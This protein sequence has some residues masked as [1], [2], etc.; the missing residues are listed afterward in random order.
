[1]NFQNF[2]HS[3]YLNFLISCIENIS[4]STTELNRS[5]GGI[6]S[7]FYILFKVLLFGFTIKSFF[8][9]IL[10]DVILKIKENSVPETMNI[11]GNL[12]ASDNATSFILKPKG[13]LGNMS[14]SGLSPLAQT[15]SS[16][17][18]TLFLNT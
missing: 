2:G 7:T 8:V 15:P 18:G 3:F 6:F 17:M 13:F 10:Y 14:F 4:D 5:G 12:T 16:L 9:G 1:M 11:M